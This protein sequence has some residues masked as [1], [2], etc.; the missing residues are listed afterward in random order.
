[1][2]APPQDITHTSLLLSDVATILGAGHSVDLL[3]HRRVGHPAEH[4]ARGSQCR[5]VNESGLEYR[6]EPVAELESGADGGC[7]IP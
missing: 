6:P 1:M 3:A 5:C 2:A 4:D 7:T